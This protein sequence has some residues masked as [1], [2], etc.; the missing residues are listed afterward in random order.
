MGGGK[1]APYQLFPCN[2]YKRR[3]SSQ[4]FLIFSF[5]PFATQTIEPEPKGPPKKSGFSD[6][7]LIKSR[8]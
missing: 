2:F 7:I 8:L 4:N 5:N 3:I 6:Q 1:K